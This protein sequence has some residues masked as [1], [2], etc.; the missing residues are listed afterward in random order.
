MDDTTRRNLVTSMHGEAFAFAKYTL[1]AEQARRG[2]H[3]A[4]ARLFEETAAVELHEH[5]KEE[6]EL[7]GL[8]RSDTENLRDAV[9]GEA[10]EIDTMYRE[11]SEQA[12]AA[13]EIEAAE[14]FLEVR[15]DELAHRPR[16]EAALAQL[17]HE[18]LAIA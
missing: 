18:S 9:E 1:F 15:G 16:F 4:L 6:A 11:F 14:R 12:K 7:A 2:G 3:E 5:F 17:Q 10:Y 13:G 8:V